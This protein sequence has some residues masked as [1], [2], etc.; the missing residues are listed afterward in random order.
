MLKATV[1]LLVCCAAGLAEL[2]AVPLCLSLR[3]LNLSCNQLASVGAL[4]AL[5]ALEELDLSANL[6]TN[7]G[8]PTL[9]R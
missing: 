4:G 8:I 5:S 7:L 9:A 1:S 6:V 3:V 2:G